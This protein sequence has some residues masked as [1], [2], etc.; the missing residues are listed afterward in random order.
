MEFIKDL[1]HY[2]FHIVNYVVI[3]MNID[4]SL[5]AHDRTNRK[6][7]FINPTKILFFIPY[8]I[9][10]CLFE[11]S[12]IIQFKTFYRSLILFSCLRIPTQINI[13]S[14]ID[15]GHEGWIDIHKIDFDSLF[16]KIGTCR[17]TI[18]PYD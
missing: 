6:K 15:S 14:I 10:H 13:F 5:F 9:I 17:K 4:G 11:L 2:Y 7:I 18:P 16:F 3:Q 8:V 1:I 12:E